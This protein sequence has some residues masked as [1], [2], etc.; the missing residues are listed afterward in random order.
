MFDLSDSATAEV[1][2]KI[3]PTI[4]Q[5][6]SYVLPQDSRVNDGAIE[7]LN[8]YEPN[9]ECEPLGTPLT[10]INDPLTIEHWKPAEPQFCKD[11]AAH[12]QQ[13]K[14]TIQKWFVDLKEIASCFDESQLRLSDDRYTPLAVELLG[15]RYFAGS[16]K[17]WEK[18]LNERYEE[19]F[20]HL[21]PEISI[22]PTEVLP[23]QNEVS[24]QRPDRAALHIG[25]SLALPAI[26][27]LISPGNDTAHLMQ[28]Q[29]KLEQFEQLQQEAIA[30]MQQQYDEAQALNA[31]YQEATSLS[32]Q[33]LLQE[34]QL[35]G[36]Q[37]GFAALQFKQQA[38][39]ATIQSAESGT[40]PGKPQPGASQPQAA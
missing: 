19:R 38:F 18:I 8:G 22:S 10:D 35:R 4:A 29:Q 9:K 16:K 37:L 1:F 13:G 30:Q 20:A 2:E 6:R 32:D 25:S 24:S 31:Q 28:I 36:V 40:P 34:F 23:S 5:P 26:P 14:R 21:A 15:D 39:K 11:I 3:A 33:L 27:V 17:K 7:N 12:Y